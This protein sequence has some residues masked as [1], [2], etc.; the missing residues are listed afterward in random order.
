MPLPQ[1]LVTKIEEVAEAAAARAAGAHTPRAG[2]PQEE[3]AGEAVTAKK[4]QDSH[5]ASQ[6][7]IRSGILDMEADQV[8]AHLGH[9][10]DIHSDTLDAKGAAGGSGVLPQQLRH[11]QR[12]HVVLRRVQPVPGFVLAGRAPNPKGCGPAL[13]Q[14]LGGRRTSFCSLGFSVKNPELEMEAA[15]VLKLLP[16]KAYMPQ[17]LLVAPGLPLFVMT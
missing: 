4:V 10:G 7:Q 17:N 1:A 8:H 15:E 11:L 14:L 9:L 6:L 16:S 12:L 3:Q 5:L 13:L 2:G